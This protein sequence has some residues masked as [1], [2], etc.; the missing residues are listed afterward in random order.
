VRWVVW[1]DE[2]AKRELILLIYCVIILLF[3]RAFC[4]FVSVVSFAVSIPSPSSKI[5]DDPA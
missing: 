4:N 1:G 3:C 5:K 2:K